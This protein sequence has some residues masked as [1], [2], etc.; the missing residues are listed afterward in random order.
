MP[1]ATKW[2]VATVLSVAA[3]NF[4]TMPAEEYAGDAIAVRIETIGLINS[5]RWAVPPSITHEWG[6]RGQYFYENAN[7]AFYPKYGI[8]NTLIYLPPLW[9]QKIATGK[10]NLYSDNT[11]YLNL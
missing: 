7:G 3:I 1:V 4:V 11:F 2:M 5:G 6:E 8:L 9:A 10:L